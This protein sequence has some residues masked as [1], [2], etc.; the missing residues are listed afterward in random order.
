[1]ATNNPCPDPPSHVVNF[2]VITVSDTRTT[3]ND[4]SGN[5]IKQSLINAGHIIS[6]YVIVKDEPDQIRP[7]MQGLVNNPELDAIILNG[8]TGIAP[9]DTT[10]DAIASLLEKT[11]P[12]FGE[13]FRYLSWQEVG[14]RAIASRA[15]AGIYQN[16]LVF[17]L[18]GSS[19]AVKLAIEQL[20]QPEIIH[21]VRQ[22]R[23]LH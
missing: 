15:V 16:K 6:S 4:K 10:Y 23:G 8:G 17:S 13:M 11:L 22:L 3:E 20:I 14:S 7:Y 19:N 18:P 1:M 21:L 12:G 9:R 2:A 5:F